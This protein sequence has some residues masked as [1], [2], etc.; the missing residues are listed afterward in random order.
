[1]PGSC[2]MRCWALATQ[3]KPDLQ[4]YGCDRCRSL[5]LYNLRGV[6]PNYRCSGTLVP[7]DP[8]E[9]LRD[10]QYYRLYTGLTPQEK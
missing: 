6:C 8:R 7:C 5:T 3:V 4:W 1:M 10:N 2:D 9:M